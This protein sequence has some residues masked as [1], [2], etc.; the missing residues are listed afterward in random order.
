MCAV[1][2]VNNVFDDNSATIHTTDGYDTNIQTV[3]FCCFMKQLKCDF[4]QAKTSL[5][6]LCDPGRRGK[7]TSFEA[8]AMQY[9]LLL[10]NPYRIIENKEQTEHSDFTLWPLTD[11]QSVKTSKGGLHS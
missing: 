9:K 10:G 8:L 7:V 5:H 4:C 3:G 2:G 1:H 6:F 11:L